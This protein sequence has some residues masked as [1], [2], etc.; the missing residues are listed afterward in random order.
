MKIRP[1]HYILLPFL[2]LFVLAVLALLVCVSPIVLV[3]LLGTSAMDYRHRRFKI[4][5]KLKS[6]KYA[7]DDEF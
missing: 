4:R 6:R 5:E 7:F 1:Q 3:Y 2:S